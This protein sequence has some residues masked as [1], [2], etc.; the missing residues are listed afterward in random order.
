MR[1]KIAA[2]TQ[3][4]DRKTFFVSVIVARW[5]RETRRAPAGVSGQILE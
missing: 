4:T 3:I 2:V 1:A 5:R